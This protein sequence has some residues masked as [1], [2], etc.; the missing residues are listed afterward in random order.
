MIAPPAPRAHPPS[1]VREG[2]PP[3][4]HAGMAKPA[5]WTL[6][7]A[8]SRQPRTYTCPFCRGRLHAMSPHVVI[9]PEEARRLREAL[10]EL[11]PWPA[12]HVR[13]DVVPPAWRRR[14]RI[15]G[16]AFAACGVLNGLAPV[17]LMLLHS[18]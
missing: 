17:A 4:Q 12:A 2:Q 9:P 18:R 15:V 14:D 5:W 13:T 8:Q 1:G 6:R 11:P 3:G 16:T 10:P 7:R